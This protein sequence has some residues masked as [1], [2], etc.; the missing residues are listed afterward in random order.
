VSGANEREQQNAEPRKQRLA[1]LEQPVQDASGSMQDASAQDPGSCAARRS[2]VSA[3]AMLRVKAWRCTSS[4]RATNSG[5]AAAKA[6]KK[7]ATTRL[8][9]RRER[10]AGSSNDNTTPIAA[11]NSHA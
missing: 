10:S 11:A 1:V 5:A 6:A 4:R 7:E 9:E 3:S 2:S 8:N